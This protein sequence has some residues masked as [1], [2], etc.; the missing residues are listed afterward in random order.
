MPTEVFVGLGSNI[1]PERHLRAAVDAIRERF[2]LIGISPVY[3]NA[4]VGFEG[5]DFLNMVIRLRCSA[6]PAELE[7]FFSD[8]ERACG[9]RRGARSEGVGAM[10]PRT[11]DVDLLVY[12]SVV[13]PELRLPRSDVLRYAFV[14]RPLA[15][16]APELVHPVTGRPIR[17]E[18]D[19]VADE[20]PS[21]EPQELLMSGWGDRV[22][23]NA[24]PRT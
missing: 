21:M 24:V 18:W 17:L 11:L 2:T 9:R 14:L 1:D 10:G 5:D 22:H 7:Q 6:G 13:D 12:G 19:A 4:A 16:L 15:D 23:G 3:R 20:S 8:V